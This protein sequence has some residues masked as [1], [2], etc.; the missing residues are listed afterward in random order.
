MLT[1]YLNNDNY[2]IANSYVIGDRITDMQ[3]A[4]NLGCRGIWLNNDP[5][6]GAGEVADKAAVL[7][8]DGTIAIE[9][10]QWQ[11]IYA[12]LS[13]GL[14]QVVHERNTNETQVKIESEYRR[15]RQSVY[16]YRPWLF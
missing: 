6:L 3:L 5:G 8:N 2:D 15:Q 13:L 14:R 9:T 7:H 4:K 11:A 10:T 1:D 16:C 12:Y